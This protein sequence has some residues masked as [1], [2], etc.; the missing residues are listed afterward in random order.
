MAVVC[1]WM[2]HA[3]KHLCQSYVGRD[4]VLVGRMQFIV[5]SAEV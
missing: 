1:S 4:F 2:D 3:Y 5:L